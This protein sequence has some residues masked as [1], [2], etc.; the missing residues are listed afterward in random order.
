MPNKPAALEI[1]K[2]MEARDLSMAWVARRLG[3]SRQ[4]L[5]LVLN[6]PYEVSEDQAA[7]I[8]EEIRRVPAIR[9]ARR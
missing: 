5:S 4:Y 8:L 6:P 9:K 7:A 1:R 3:V 2:A